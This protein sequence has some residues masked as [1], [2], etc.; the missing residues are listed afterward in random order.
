MIVND[1]DSF[2]GAVNGKF[3]GLDLME[4]LYIGGHPNFNLIHNLAGH[5]KGFVGKFFSGGI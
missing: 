3:Q 2:G 1:M 5:S 4:P